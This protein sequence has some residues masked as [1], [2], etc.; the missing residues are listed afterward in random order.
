MSRLGSRGC[1][2]GPRLWMIVSMSRLGLL[3]VVVGL[4]AGCSKD[5]GTASTGKG[6]TG[7]A[8]VVVAPEDLLLSEPLPERTVVAGKR[9][10][11]LDPAA[12]GLAFQNELRPENTVAYVYM[13]AGLTV[14]D[15]DQDGLPDV[16]L[17][18]QDGQNKLFRQIAPLKFE[19]VTGKAGAGLGGGDAWGTA[20]TFADVDGDGDLDLYVCNLESPNLLFLNQGDGTF[21]EKAGAF[22]LGQTA[23]STG[24]AFADYDN[25]GDLDLYLLTNRVFRP[26]LAKEIAAEAKLPGRIR[27]TL[28]ELLAQELTFEL[29]GHRFMAGQQDRL[30]RNDGYAKFV[31]VTEESGLKDAGNGLSVVWWDFDNDGH[32]DIYVANDFQSP[33]QF[34]RNLG[35]GKFIDVTEERLP[36]TAFFGMGTDFGDINNDGM[37]D[38]CVADMSSTSHYMGKMLMG[39]MDQHRWFLMNSKPQQYMRNALYVNTGTKRFLE[40]AHMA[41]LASTDW[42]WT[43]RFADFDEDG[44]QDFYATNGIPVFADNP[45]IGNRVTKLWSERRYQAALDVMRNMPRIDE[46]NIARRNLGDLQFEDIGAEWGLD[47]SGV[48]HG[49]VVVDLDRDGD[50]DVITNNLNADA[51]VFE[52]RTSAS[53]RLLVE[54]R[55]HD[56]NHFGV[57]ARIDLEAGGV[58]HVRQVSL[59]RGYMSAGEAVEHF[60]LGAA[61]KID[62]LQVTWPSGRQ[63]QFEGA[64]A[65]QRLTLHEDLTAPVRSSQPSGLGLPAEALGRVPAEM[66]SEPHREREFDDFASQPLLPH[67]VS[68]LGPGMAS[69]SIT[70]A[71][72]DTWFGGAAGRAGV[73][74]RAEGKSREPVS[75]P[76]QGHAESEDMGAV[77]F[78]MDSDGDLDLYVGSGGVEVGDDDV[79]LLDRLYVN[80]GNGGYTNAPSGTLPNVRVSTSCVA[81]ADFDLDGDVDL[82][83]GGRVVPGGFPHA[84]TSTLLRNDGGKFVDVTD[85]VAP[86]CRQLG[87]VSSACWSDLDG[88]GLVDLVVAAQWQPVRVL[89]NA[90]GERLLDRTDALG[91]SSI[92][93]LW[94]GVTSTDLDGDG[95]FDLIVTNFGLNSKYTASAKKPMQLFARDIDGNGTMDVIEAKQ[96]NGVALPVRGLSC[97]GGAMPFVRKKFSTYDAFARASLGDIYG[98]ALDECLTLTCNELRHVVFENR[99]ES[100]VLHALPRLAQVSASFGVLARDVDGDGTPEIALTHNFWSPEPETGRID[101]GIGVLLRRTSAL[102][103]EAVPALESGIMM[104]HDARGLMLLDM[105]MAE[106]TDTNAS[107]V[108]FVFA[109]NDDSFL[110]VSYPVRFKPRMV[111]RLAGPDGNPNGIGAKV[112]LLRDGEEPVVRELLAGDGYL[113]QSS[114]VLWFPKAAAGTLRV[115]W[116]DG[117]VSEHPLSEAKA[118]IT[119]SR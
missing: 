39:N 15:Y 1:S 63:Q 108:Y 84:P 109:N 103:Y 23:A 69:G 3:A 30:F 94:N 99:G 51:S 93:G 68:R 59:T 16:Y 116:S 49:A 61:T 104:A 90:K 19:D 95:D 13:G 20:A 21:V 5:P 70:D 78:D 52:N 85:D 24:A 55:G 102:N 87:M 10:A 80:D 105:P 40:A 81:A 28:D 32:Q 26:T 38:L 60:G 79:V 62:K 56:G 112:T 97:S 12:T 82:F 77:F 89:G 6:T 27:K 50:L 7:S 37:F 64:V 46:K 54:L 9:F 18:S 67:R 33:D 29:D 113:T 17:V 118:R 119:L 115:N 100:F 58:K 75:G 43:V 48:T 65:N 31:D 110:G 83:V 11:R 86:L 92:H 88:D 96:A 44:R 47:E 106:P 73:L 98:S 101:G 53:N 35:S 41:G 34:Y 114:P 8:G 91:L 2:E 66:S 111:V 14:S 76:W 71:R 25:D 22:G 57:G 42:T 4:V 45:D 107:D 117:E 36:H 72:S 74:M